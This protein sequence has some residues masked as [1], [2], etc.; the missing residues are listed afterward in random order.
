MHRVRV[1]ICLCSA[2]VDTG[3]VF[4]RKDVVPVQELKLSVGGMQEALM[5]SKLVKGDLSI[6]TIEH[7]MSALC[8]FEIDNVYIDL[9]SAEVPVFDGSAAVFVQALESISALPQ[10]VPANI[11][12]F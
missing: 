10:T 3:I 9:D 8:A 6:S 7:L 5:C 2:P 4:R 1:L 11:L 12:K